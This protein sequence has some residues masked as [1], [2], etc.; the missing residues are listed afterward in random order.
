MLRVY[1]I[2]SSASTSGHG[3]CFN[4]STPGSS[5]LI[6]TLPAV[7]V[8]AGFFVC[9]CFECLELATAEAR[10]EGLVVRVERGREE[11]EED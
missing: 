7:D 2:L 5:V 8:A 11:R 9:E 3:P 6:T 1:Q 4:A 10:A